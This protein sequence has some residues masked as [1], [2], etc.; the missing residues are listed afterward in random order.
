[1][2]TNNKCDVCK[3]RKNLDEITIEYKLRVCNTCLANPKQVARAIKMSEA[4]AAIRNAMSEKW[5]NLV[6]GR[7]PRE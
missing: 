2:T 4:E 3:S 6:V 7:K 5:A 1:M